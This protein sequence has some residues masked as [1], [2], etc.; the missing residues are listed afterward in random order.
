M[1]ER[2]FD[3]IVGVLHTDVSWGDCDPAGIIFYPTY[4]R[5]FDAATWAL[6]G[7]VGHGL[8]TMI[9]SGYC[10]PLV[11]AQCE[12]VAPAEP[13]DRC[14]VRSRIARW[15]GKSFVVSHEVVRSDGATLA[16]GQE[17]RVWGRHVAG[18]GSPMK[19]QPISEELKALFRAC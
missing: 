8:K 3:S 16:R 19:G 10:M 5:W 9:E 1:A 6:F 4:F 11:G 7:S 12:F 14:E 15:G 2:E 13:G 18:P 17:T